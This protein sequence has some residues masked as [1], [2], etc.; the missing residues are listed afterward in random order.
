VLKYSVMSSCAFRFFV[1]RG[2]DEFG[3]RF[4]ARGDRES[5]VADRRGDRR[6]CAESDHLQVVVVGR[7]N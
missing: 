7:C 4:G 6:V 3:R 1:D 5:C 2:V